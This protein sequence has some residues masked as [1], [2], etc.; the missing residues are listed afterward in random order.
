MRTAWMSS[1]DMWTRSDATSGSQKIRSTL[2]Y[3]F[4]VSCALTCSRS[5]SF[6]CCSSFHRYLVDTHILNSHFF[7]FYVVSSR[8][9]RSADMLTHDSLSILV[10]FLARIPPFVSRVSLHTMYLTLPYRCIERPR[11]LILASKPMFIELFR[12][13]IE[14]YDITVHVH[15]QPPSSA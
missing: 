3:L 12:L 15:L 2:S 13:P 7:A 1:R 6:R 8:S 9:S 14:S 4:L 10:F 11:T 5:L